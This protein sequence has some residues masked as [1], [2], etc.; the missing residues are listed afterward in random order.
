MKA[1]RNRRENT[2]CAREIQL[3]D[4]EWYTAVVWRE[5]NDEGQEGYGVL[6]KGARASRWAPLGTP[7]RTV[8]H[9]ERIECDHGNGP[10]IAAGCE[11]CA[12]A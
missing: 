3:E 12:S 11:V 8:R 5:K 4:G 10:K 1:S 2:M 9:E 7:L 6:V